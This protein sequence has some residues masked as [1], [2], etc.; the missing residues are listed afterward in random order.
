MM[1]MMMITTVYSQTVTNLG[2]ITARVDII[3]RSSA[4]TIHM[5]GGLLS[6]F[7]GLNLQISPK[8]CGGTC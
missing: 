4:V 2:T 7:N 8:Q 1:M 5:F 6:P 3:D